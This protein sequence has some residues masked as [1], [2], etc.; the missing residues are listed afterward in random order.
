MKYFCSGP[1]AR[2][3]VPNAPRGALNSGKGSSVLFLPPSE[4]VVLAFFGRLS[5]IAP[6]SLLSPAIHP[7]GADKDRPSNKRS[8]CLS[9]PSVR[10][11]RRGDNGRGAGE[12]GGQRGEQSGGEK[13]MQLHPPGSSGAAPGSQ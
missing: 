13:S 1:P 5:L 8:R 10:L 6:V 9:G 11:L 4:E 7:P 12:P 3:G 2:D